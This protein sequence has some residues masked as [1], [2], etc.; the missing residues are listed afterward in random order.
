MC[1]C[2]VKDSIVLSETSRLTS[3][4]SPL[5]C[6][7]PECRAG[8]AQGPRSPG[9]MENLAQNSP[10]DSQ[11]LCVLPQYK[12]T[13][14]SQEPSRKYLEISNSF[15][16]LFFYPFQ[17]GYD[18]GIKLSLPAL[19]SHGTGSLPGFARSLIKTFALDFIASRLN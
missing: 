4:C 9:A 18:D 15:S 14:E 3:T 5:G 1:A 13:T 11:S 8:A 7:S 17:L 16:C 12:F 10:D 2:H 19:S 6:L